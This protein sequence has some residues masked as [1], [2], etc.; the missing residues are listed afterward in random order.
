M[1]RIPDVNLNR[2]QLTLIKTVGWCPYC[3]QWIAE[4]DWFDVCEKLTDSLQMNAL[5]PHFITS[6]RELL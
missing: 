5:S 1:R 3:M 2:Q 4:K 6:K